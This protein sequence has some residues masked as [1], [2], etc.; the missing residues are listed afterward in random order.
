MDGYFIKMHRAMRMRK[1]FIAT[2]YSDEF[3]TMLIK[4]KLSKLVPYIQDNKFWE[5]IYFIL[6]L[7]PPCI[8]VLLLA[9]SNK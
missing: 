8:R 2:V 6:K 4:S 7:L 5:I 1:S 9:D 3:N